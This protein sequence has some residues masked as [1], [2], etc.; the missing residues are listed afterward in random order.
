M[1]ELYALE[2]FLKNE[3]NRKSLIACVSKTGGSGDKDTTE[4]VKKEILTNRVASKL[5]W[6]GVVK[7]TT[8]TKVGIQTFPR[9]VKLVKASAQ[10]IEPKSTEKSIEECIKYWLKHA[11]RLLFVLM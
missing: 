1:A 3:N 8:V 9:V 6:K 2:T 7:K 11:K 5:N 4:R 10:A